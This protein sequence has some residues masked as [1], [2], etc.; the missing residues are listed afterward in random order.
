MKFAP[1]LAAAVLLGFS[2]PAFAQT[3]PGAW[4]HAFAME[5]QPKYGPD[6]THFDYVNADAPKGGVVRM[7]D[8]G[9]SGGS[10]AAG[11]NVGPARLGGRHG[12]P[13]P[14]SL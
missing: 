7:G 8:M 5:G 11:G 1:L 13:P 14:A 2:A 12:A 9:G 10:Y 3:A 6:Y 4:V